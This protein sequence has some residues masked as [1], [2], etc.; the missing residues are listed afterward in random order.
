MKRAR[1][2]FTAEE[3]KKIGD[4]VRAA[5][6]QTSGE[7][8][9]VVATASGRYERGEDI[10]G[11]LFGLAA[12]ALTWRYFQRIVPAHGEWAQGHNVALSLGWLLL[13]VIAGFIAGVAITNRVGWL[14]R[15]LAGHREMRREVERSAWEAFVR[16]GVAK[17]TRKTEILLYVSLLERMVCVLGDDA[18]G[19]KL[20]QQI[21][22]KIHGTI[23]DGIRQGHPANGF[24]AAIT[25]SGELLRQHFPH[26][27]GE[28]KALT[29]ELRIIDYAHI[30]VNEGKRP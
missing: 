9:P 7:I 2:F 25:E 14:K 26:H 21:W 11:L 22:D 19:Q 6:Q 12:L 24:C 29:N 15:L 4:A 16:F 5:E 17:A 10:G 3:Q 13:I 27:A 30:T 28:Q 18:I 23:V 1:D 20:D 8:V